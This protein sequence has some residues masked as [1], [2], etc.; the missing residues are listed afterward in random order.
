MAALATMSLNLNSTTTAR[1]GL[2]TQDAAVINVR[3][4]QLSG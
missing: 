3:T 4:Y 1:A 2:T